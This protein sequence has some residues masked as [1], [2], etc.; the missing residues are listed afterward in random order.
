MYQL[1]SSGLKK[2]M[3]KFNLDL[4]ETLLW[5]AGGGRGVVRPA[6]IQRGS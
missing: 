5:V 4:D 3:C 6:P 2:G 1:N